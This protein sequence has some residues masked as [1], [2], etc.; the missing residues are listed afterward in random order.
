MKVVETRQRTQIAIQ[1]TRKK[2]KNLRHD[3]GHGGA[4]LHVSPTFAGGLETL[5]KKNLDSVGKDSD[6]IFL[7]QRFMGIYG[8]PSP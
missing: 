1:S 5:L 8:L 6:T 2:S 4:V 3:D 7:K